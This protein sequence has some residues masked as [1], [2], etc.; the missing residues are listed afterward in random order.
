VSANGAVQQRGGRDGP[1]PRVANS[2]R[3][4]PRALISKPSVL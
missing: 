3:R 1:Q 4:R 2:Q